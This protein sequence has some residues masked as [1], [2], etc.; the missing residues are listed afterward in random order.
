MIHKTAWAYQPMP[1]NLRSKRR[2]KNRSLWGS[3]K[4]MAPIQR[5]TVMIC[6]QTADMYSKVMGLD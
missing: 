5:A 2:E 4:N 6:I 3:P 1:F